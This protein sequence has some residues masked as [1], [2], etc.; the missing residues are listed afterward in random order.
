LQNSK[1]RLIWER[2]DWTKA[3]KPE[4]PTFTGNSSQKNKNNQK[5]HSKDALFIEMDRFDNGSM[6][7]LGNGQFGIVYRVRLESEGLKKSGFHVDQKGCCL[8]DLKRRQ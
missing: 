7:I 4:S 3:E 5:F 2:F 8:I 1:K 6:K